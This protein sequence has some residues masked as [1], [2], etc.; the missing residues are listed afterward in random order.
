MS[1]PEGPAEPVMLNADPNEMRA[2]AE[3]MLNKK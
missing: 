1:N 3:A 2:R